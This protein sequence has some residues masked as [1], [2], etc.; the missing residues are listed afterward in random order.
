[1]F[2]SWR[3]MMVPMNP[4]LREHERI[5]AMVVFAHVVDLGSMTRAAERLRLT[6]SAVSKQLRRLETSMGVQLLRRT[7]RRI[8]LTEAG[9]RL[10]AQAAALLTVAKSADDT[11]GELQHGVVGELRVTA[12]HSWGRCCLVPMLLP[13]LL[14]HP[15]LKVRL[16]L[17]DRR[18]D[19]VSEG[20]DVAIR[21]AGRCPEGLV[22]R[23]LARQDF[24]LCGRPG[25][26]VSVPSDLQGQ[27]CLLY[28]EGDQSNWWTFLSAARE[29]SRV[30]VDGPL[31]ANS[32]E[33]LLGAAC[34]GIGL[35]LLPAY[36]AA[37]PLRDRILMRYL[38][39]WDAEP[40]I[41]GELSVL[42]VRDRHRLPKMKVFL[43]YLFSGP[44][45][46]NIS[47]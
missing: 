31:R 21:Q 45:E 20:F 8:G 41:P 10:H 5:A 11:V 15:A 16:L 36:V 34:A 30:Q 28:G 39:D 1:M 19:L 24:L 18:V 26:Q 42:W 29:P 23:P 40:P 35:A 2:N 6:T 4:E 33:A 47:A 27:P 22:A 9:S 14:R 44:R 7:T 32:S 38:P 17:T 37:Q 25:R 46:Q 12:P 13:L 43:D 3:L